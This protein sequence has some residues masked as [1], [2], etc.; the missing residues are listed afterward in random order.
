MGKKAKVYLKDPVPYRY[1]FLPQPQDLVHEIPSQQF[2]AI[3]AVDCGDFFRI[4]DGHEK[5]KG[6]G[7]IISIDHHDTNEAFGFLNILD[8]RASSTAEII[9]LILKSLDIKIGFNIAVNL[10][11]AILT[12]TGSFRYDNTNSRAFVIC[13]EMMHA[14]V[15]PS[16]VAAEVYESHPRERFELLCQA[17]AA[18][19]TYHGN[20]L[21]IIHVT[22]DMFRQTQSSRE[23]SE[24]FVEFLKEMRGL[25]VAMMARQ[26]G[27]DRYKISMRSKGKVDV[28]SI[29]AI[30][31]GGGH[32]KAA[33]CVI[34]GNIDEVKKKLVEATVL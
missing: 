13:E 18:M 6:M 23:H 33:G 28:A 26:I 17:L 1:R 5:L 14:G 20:K 22:E 2:D 31:G 15:V 25:E 8:Q 34:E 19:E 16:H 24:G 10:Y 27:K 29:A 7:P 9:Y 32:K 11:T 12:D 30:F 21:A 4:G 3:F